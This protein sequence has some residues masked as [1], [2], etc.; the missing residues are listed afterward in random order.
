MKYRI[1]AI[2]LF[3]PVIVW[4]QDACTNKSILD[5]DDADKQGNPNG[6]TYTV[7]GV[8][9]SFTLTDINNRVN[10][11]AFQPDAN[12]GVGSLRWNQDLDNNGESSSLTINT[13]GEAL[14]DFCILIYGINGNDQVAVN[15][16]YN[17]VN[18]AFQ[19]SI[20]GTDG[21]FGIDIYQVCFTGPI[22]E[23][24][25]I[26]FSNSG[27]NPP[28]Q[29]IGLGDFA[30]CNIQDTDDDGVENSVDIDDDNDGIL[31]AVEGTADPDGDGFP[32]DQ[33]ID[34]DGDGIIDNIEAQATAVY[35]AP[36]GTDTDN[37]GWDDSYD[38]DNGGVAITLVDTNTDGT[39]DY[40]DDDS[41]GDTVGDLIEGNDIDFNGLA[42]VTP[43]TGGNRNPSGI[44]TDGDG[45]DDSFDAID[46]RGGAGNAG[47]LGRNTVPESLLDNDD[48]Y[49]F[50]DTDDDGDG[51]NTVDELTDTNGDGI[52]EFVQT[53]E[54]GSILDFDDFAVGSTPSSF[55]VDGVT[56][57]FEFADASG[58]VLNYDIY[59]ELLD[60]DNNIFSEHYVR[61]LQ[62][63]ENATQYS[64]MKVKF[65]RP[66]KGFSFNLIDIDR[67]SPQFT[68][69]VSVNVY[70]D[71][72]V[73]VLDAANIITGRFNQLNDNNFV[74]G[75]ANSDPVDYFG[76]V[77]ISVDQ[78]VDSL[79]IRYANPDA[80]LNGGVNDQA[81]G[82]SDFTWCGID[83][84]FDNVLDVYDNDDNN[85]GINDVVEAGGVEGVDADP[86]A[87]ADGDKVPN[88]QDA[89]FAGFTDANADGIDDNFDY[90][91]DGIPDHLDKDTDNDGLPDAVEANGG[92]LPDNMESDGS[93]SAAYAASATDA[94]GDGIL[95]ELDPDEGGTA[96]AVNNS[97]GDAVADFRDLDADNDGLPDLV[98]AGGIDADNDGQ[99]DNFNDQDTDGISDQ[100]DPDNFGTPLLQGALIQKA[101]NSDS[102]A[103]P[104]YR[105]VDSDADGI[106]DNV[107]AQSVAD[108]VAPG[109][110]DT[111]GDG[112]VD[113]YDTDNGGT[114]IT[115]VDTD[116]D[117]LE[118]Y[119]DTDADN[120]GVGDKIESR[121]ADLDG[122]ADINAAN[123]DADN[124]GL[125]DN[126]DPD[127]G[128]T[129][130]P[131]LSSDSDLIPDYRDIDD[132]ND[133]I[134][135]SNEDT[136]GNNRYYDD[137][138]QGGGAVPD[139]LFSTN[140]PDRD[141]IANDTDLDD[142]NDGISDIDQ[143]YGVN[144]GEDAD[145]DGTPNYLDAD[146]IHPTYGAFVDANSDGVNDIFD[147]DRDGVPNHFDLDSDGDG[148]PNA[149]E[150]N[151]G[152]L[153][154]NMT[155]DGQVD[156]AYAQV[157]DG[158]GDGVVNDLDP[159]AGGT[160][161]VNPDFDGDGF[162]DALDQDADG[163]GIT[164]AQ[165]AQATDTNDNG[166]NDTFT[167]SDG[168]GNADYRDS[169]ADNDGI[170]DILESRAT[171][172]ADSG[173][174]TDLDGL[175][176]AF[177]ADNG[178]TTLTGYDQDGDTIPDY[179]DD[180]SD[181]D[182]IS[183]LVE[184]N[185][186]NADGV[187]DA[188]P[189]GTDSDGDGLDDNFEGGV[190][191]QNTDG[192][193]EPDYRDND[194]DGDG[195]S[196]TDELVD[197]NPANGTPDYL[198]VSSDFCGG[199]LTAKDGYAKAIANSSGAV[200]TNSA[201]GAPNYN[202]GADNFTDLCYTNDPG[203]Y[204]TL[205]LESS[206]PGGST[207]A[208]YVT[209]NEAGSGW[210]VSSSQDGVVFSNPTTYSNLVQRNNIEIRTYNVPAGGIRYLRLTRAAGTPYVD[211]VIF[212]ECVSDIDNDEVADVD[213]EDSDN[214]GLS[215]T[216]EGNGT[217]PSADADADGTLN[218]LDADFAGFEDI[219]G[220]GVDDNFD[221][222][223]DGIANH[224]DLDSDNDGI[225]DAVE[226]NGGSL[227]AN[228]SSAGAYLVS[229]ALANDTDG[230]GYVNDVDSDNG[231]VALSNPDTDADG[232]NDFTDRDSDND[233]I[234]D[235][236]E[237][238]G[239]DSDRNGI[240]DNLSD[241]D[242]DG[243]ADSVDPE[244]G[245]TALII[246]N[247]DGTDNPD[248]LD[249]D[250]DNDSGGGS[251]GLPD[252][253]EAHDSNF[254]GTPA[255]DDNGN[256]TLDANEGNIDLDGDGILDAFD[257]S[258]GGIGA[259][260]PDVDSDGNANYRDSDDDG[261]GVPTASEDANGDG[262][263]FN[264][265]TEGQDVNY[266]ATYS[267]VPDYL[268]NPISP[269]PVELL[270]FVAHWVTDGVKLQWETVY[271][272]NNDYFEIE[273][274]TDGARF[275]T[276]G[277]VSG[278]GNTTGLTAY[279]YLD[280]VKKYGA[281]YY[282]L[283]QVDFDG[284]A[285]YSSNRYV[286]SE[287]SRMPIVEVF[288]VPTPDICTISVVGTQFEIHY[289][290]VDLEGRVLKSGRFQQSVSLDIQHLKAGAYV[291]RLNSASF[292]KSVRVIKK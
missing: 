206:A 119:R 239:A 108:F 184:G 74:E 196:T 268:Y 120:D 30:W 160:P 112:W 84:D 199:G 40:L 265:F 288:P 7:D 260:L 224:L 97:D 8:D 158:D 178:G 220:D 252:I 234:T 250:S 111:D 130:A 53:C 153:P 65:S 4:A 62:N 165:E 155:E 33:D 243:L 42:D 255:W 228:M 287:L 188:T 269:L 81:G 221:F 240:L 208:L 225:P 170:L 27:G 69:Y 270:R 141:G 207:I 21:A 64:T 169:D 63:L 280:P 214:D 87:D 291:I 101:R 105:D 256:L 231:G 189:I 210:T 95:A 83:S 67:N 9:L 34:S 217:D 139:Y 275:K 179:L 5:W 68:D 272:E 156:P 173:N 31:D 222:D 56:I 20:I 244:N 157:N 200:R 94:D 89:D 61:V 164:D 134:L 125:D 151:E 82:M 235:T 218:Y 3:I 43:D 75:L 253:F 60:A 150:A 242:A 166:I 163:D 198:E 58:N 282:R 194:D 41:D 152:I 276:I 241:T 70:S 286:E 15:G 258:E 281:Y 115:L 283:K 99:V 247:T 161:L 55:N 18:T 107:E 147:T 186:A 50:R 202:S 213:D 246:I 46:G 12:Y 135:T 66:L 88:Y 254:D 19:A 91:L 159:D 177:D 23:F 29:T 103:F 237:A 25:V 190:A 98:E 183:D 122:K 47:P 51:T 39:D 86:S 44:D 22:D 289:Q 175:D 209:S 85:N 212:D 185:D 238:G 261:D 174:D 45:L 145:V 191:L 49:N 274:S 136:N 245:G 17:A 211:G 133:G 197:Q 223:L 285:V 187:A 92:I 73:V 78:T 263:F 230:D 181:G 232:L 131:V 216:Q 226:A 106:T 162:A 138:S 195:I 249:T 14:Y 116:G 32:N 59:E 114:P 203:E 227:P 143:G 257:P 140:D 100:Y 127:S 36:S 109:G 168:D 10:D 144:P 266:S 71:A 180:D 35:V 277:R 28:D 176:D 80:G 205:D 171:G 79:V 148:I 123:S 248:Y 117:G 121:D 124:D 126:F 233:G 271:E 129:V 251:P 76:H 259:A 132:D 273:R 142:N 77:H 52:P 267:G 16:S 110:T 264:D 90:D 146:Y 192:T 72:D 48:E 236:A 279:N 2:M 193:G 204:V 172:V 215:N 102:D 24:T 201:L 11:G 278:K 262:N 182:G 104:D 13:G 93:F 137:F 219:N 128:G 118:D 290:L 54:D 229:Y 37:D 292:Q 167:D 96:L 6:Q 57:T 284:S 113:E 26:F 149:V 1:T 154:A 38:S